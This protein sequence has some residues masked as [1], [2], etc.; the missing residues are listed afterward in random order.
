MPLY[1]YFRAPTVDAVRQRMDADSSSPLP[2]FDGDDF[3]SMDPSVVL[4]ELVAVATGQPWSTTLVGDSLIWPADPAE[5]EGPWVTVLGDEARDTLA[6]I[7][8]SRFAELAAQWAGTGDVIER[9]V[10]LAGRARDNDESLF[11]WMAL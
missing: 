6:A 5:H 10:A 8:A 1:D 2:A 3:K 9:I 11:C 4:G 7:P